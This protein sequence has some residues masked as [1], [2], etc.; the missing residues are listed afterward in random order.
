MGVTFIIGAYFG[1]K[2]AIAFD[3]KLVRQFFAMA[4]IAVGIKMLWSK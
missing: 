3:T 4:I 1:G 2:T